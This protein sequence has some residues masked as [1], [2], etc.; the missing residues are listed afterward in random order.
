MTIFKKLLTYYLLMIALFFV[1]RV[2]LFTLYLDR[3]LASDVNYYLSFL[4]GLKMDTMLASA[5]L[6]IPL[7][8]LSFAPKIMATIV[9]SIL[10]VYFLVVFG[11][12][13]YIENATIPFF[14]QYDVRPNYKFVEY[15]EYPKEVFGM[16]LADYKLAL[17]VAFVMI[18]LFSL[19]YWRKS[20]ESFLAVFELIWWKR[21]LLF[22]PIGILLFIGIR[23]SFGH[24]PANISDALYS[25][26]RIVNEVTKNS[27]YSI[28]YAIYANKSYATKAVK[29][30]GVIDI[31]E[32]MLRVSSRLGISKNDINSSQSPFLRANKTHFPS[33][34]KKNLVIFLQESLGYQFISSELTPEVLKLKKESLWFDQLYSNGTRSVRGIAGVASGILAIPG[35]GVVKRNKSQHNFFSF[36]SLLNPKGY[37]TGFYYGGESRFDNMR[38]WFLGNGFDEIIEQKDYTDPKFVATWGVSDEDL[39]DKA[40]QRFSQL[41]KEGTPFAVMMFSSSNHSPFEYPDGRIEPVEG[42][43]K[44]SLKNA[45]KY[46]DYAIGKF[47]KDAKKLDYYKDTIFVV[48]ADHNVRVYGDDAVPID[49]FHIPAFIIGEG[50]EAKVYNKLASQPDILATAL[51]Y[52]G[53]DFTVPILGHSIWSDA[54]QEINLMQFNENYALRVGEKVAIIEP[55]QPAQTFLY[56]E[57]KLV[58]TAH[59]RELEKDALAFVVTLNHLYNKELF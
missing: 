6:V 8:L 40:N 28:A 24:R 50:I 14:A 54:K 58:A 21:A 38:S 27:F 45:I 30:Y 33:S 59:D 19:L 29:R 37:H 20:K 44:Y 5:L 39:A 26:S 10:R 4:Y 34:K 51:D 2:V 23:S 17:V 12:I 9:D 3:I 13:I 11:I 47:F 22:L 1:G 7:L 52:L 41:Y 32:A 56:Q 43:A 15:L 16:I 48:V 35:K 36:A 42:E 49:M 55:N 31:E 18:G 57:K 53:E 25:S 46:A